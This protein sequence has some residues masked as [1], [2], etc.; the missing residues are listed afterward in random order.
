MGVAIYVIVYL[1]CRPSET[2]GG[3]GWNFVDFG[4][5]YAPT[6]GFASVSMATAFTDEAIWKTFASVEFESIKKRSDPIICFVV[7]GP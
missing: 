4:K 7:Y 3:V 5:N 6:S 2:A 1:I